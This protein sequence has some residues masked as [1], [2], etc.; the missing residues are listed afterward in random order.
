[1]VPYRYKIDTRYNFIDQDITI[2]VKN[3]VY[4]MIIDQAYIYEQMFI[5]GFA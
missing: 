2:T 3:I 4:Y 5:S 1:M